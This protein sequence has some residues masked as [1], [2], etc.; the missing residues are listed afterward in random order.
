M[1]SR[2]YGYGDVPAG[3]LLMLARRHLV[4]SATHLTL[5]ASTAQPAAGQAFSSRDVSG[6]AS[7]A[8]F[9]RHGDS[10]CSDGLGDLAIAIGAME[11]AAPSCCRLGLLAGGHLVLLAGA[12]DLPRSQC[13]SGL[14]PSTRPIGPRCTRGDLTGRPTAGPPPCP[15]G[16]RARVHPAREERGPGRCQGRGLLRCG[17]DRQRLHRLE[18]AA[19]GEAELSGGEG[20]RVTAT[21]WPTTKRTR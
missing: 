19:P 6:A 8:H 21:P 7:T 15:G 11:L 18:A 20:S 5:F 9:P 12:V 14:T 17:E 3:C 13:W 16:A 4:S 2:A 10:T 1:S